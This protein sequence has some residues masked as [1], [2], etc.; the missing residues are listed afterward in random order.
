MNVARIKLVL[1]FLLFASPFGL[2]YIAFHF[3]T[4]TSFVNKGTLLN[5]V[6]VLTELPLEVDSTGPEKWLKQPKVHGKWVLLQMDDLPCSAA[7]ESKLVGMRQAHAALGKHQLR[8]QR[9]FALEAKTPID[10]AF[11]ARAPDLVWLRGAE[12][13]AQLR[14]AVPQG[15][16]PREFLFLV[17][18]LG[19]LFM[20]YPA[21]VDLKDLVKDMERLLKASRIG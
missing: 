2:A 14:K 7:C 15:A 17:D 6:S 19:N 16:S 13:E 5:P 18:P 8:V 11:A 3:W 21:N 12:L 10:A 20:R 1:I 4:P 9:A